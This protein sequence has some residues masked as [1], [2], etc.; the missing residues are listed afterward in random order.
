ML[1]EA[2]RL[3]RSMGDA[4]GAWT[5]AFLAWKTW[6]LLVRW[7]WRYWS[8][9]RFSFFVFLEQV[10]VIGVLHIKQIIVCLLVAASSLFISDRY[11]YRVQ[12]IG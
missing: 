7:G 3:S 2:K 10:G 1:G 12:R 6:E 5:G 11:I 4:L 8:R 9:F